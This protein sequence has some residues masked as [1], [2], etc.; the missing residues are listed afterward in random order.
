MAGNHK[1]VPL[2]DAI[3]E[4]KWTLGISEGSANDVEL[5]ILAQRALTNL[6][7]LNSMYIANETLDVIDGEAALPDNVLKIMAI[8]YCDSEGNPYGAYLADFSFLGA[9][10]CSVPTDV[11]SYNYDNIVMLNNNVLTWKYPDNAPVKIKVACKVRQIDSDGF[12]MIYD[13]M[14]DAVRLSICCNFGLKHIDKYPQWQVW[15]K[16]WKAQHDRVISIDAYDSFQRNFGRIV[17]SS[18]PRIITL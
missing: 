12:I 9:C 5:S 18:N 4:A 8:R 16:E 13:Y 2:E 1:H 3:T 17:K 14:V 10:N 11:E 7:N 6:N 15:K